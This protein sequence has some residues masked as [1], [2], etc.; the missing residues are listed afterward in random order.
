MPDQ[1]LITKTLVFLRDARDEWGKLAEAA[2]AL[3]EAEKAQRARNQQARCQEEISKLLA[4]LPP[5][6]WPF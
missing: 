4:D 6:E 1:E 2:D 5:E 3:G